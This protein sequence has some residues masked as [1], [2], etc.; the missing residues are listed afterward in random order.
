MT[1]PDDLEPTWLMRA[2]R[3]IGIKEIVGLKHHPRILE[4]HNATRLHAKEDEVAWCSAFVCWVM[5]GSGIAST[6]SAAARSWL[7]WGL[8]LSEPRPG[9]V[10]VLER[11]TKDNPNAA[12]VGIYVGPGEEVGT[13]M[14]LG[15]NQSNQVCIKSYTKERVMAYRWPDLP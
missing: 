3:E 9:C 2:R 14:V 1:F 8:D 7:G 15:G 11:H 10:V 13:I 12:H 5:E 6:R 4:Y